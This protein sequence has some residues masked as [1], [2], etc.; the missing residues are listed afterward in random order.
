M[1]MG[2]NVDA[3][4]FVRHLADRLRG[5]LE[6]VGAD[7]A[8]RLETLAEPGHDRL[9]DDGSPP[10]TPVRVEPR[11]VELDRVR[12][13]GYDGVPLGT[14][15]TSNAARR[16]VQIAVVAQAERV[17]HGHD[18]RGVGRLDCDR[19]RWMAS[20][21]EYGPFDLV[22]SDA[23]TG[24]PL[25]T[26]TARGPP[27]SSG[28]RCCQDR[29]EGQPVGRDGRQR[30]SETWKTVRAASASSGNGTLR[31]GSQRW[32]PAASV[33]RRTLMS[34]SPSRTLTLS[35]PG[36]GRVRRSPRRRPAPSLN[37]ASARGTPRAKARHSQQRSQPCPLDFLPTK[38]S[39]A[40]YRRA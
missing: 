21:L 38:P 6:R 20:G 12:A 31:I 27:V 28:L 23:V 35:P 40:C 3:A 4:S 33:S 34:I 13:G 5:P 17:D 8:G 2:L 7:V 24:T 11:D 25:W 19:R 15:S 16:D 29:V 18:V 14:R 9:I 39:G 37:A 26:R 30:L 36:D 22:A 1:A 10:A 32:R